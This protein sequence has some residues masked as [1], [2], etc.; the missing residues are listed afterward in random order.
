VRSEEYQL[1]LSACRQLAESHPWLQRVQGESAEESANSIKEEMKRFLGE[2]FRDRERVQKTALHTMQPLLAV[3]DLGLLQI[4]DLSHFAWQHH[5][6]R[7]KLIW[8]DVVLPQRPR[9]SH[10]F[11]LLTSN[12]AQALQAVRVLLLAGFEGQSRAMIR[13]FV[14]LADM[15]LA[16]VADEQ[17]Y[18][19]YI[20]VYEDEK[21]TQEHWRKHLAPGV[22]RQRLAKLDDELALSKIT[23]IPAAQVRQDTY[24]WVS[25]FSHVDLVAHL[26]SA[27]PQSLSGAGMAPLAMLGEV[28]EA[29]RATFARVL[30]YLWL[31]FIHF[32]RVLWAQ[33]RWNRFRGN[34]SRRWYQYRSSVFHTLFRENYALLQGITSEDSS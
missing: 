16:V 30:L 26:I 3:F 15:S 29:T 11:Y 17:C 31:F 12:L 4:C 2:V 8:P 10:V 21:K 7:V 14:E 1:L 23:S 20:T 18:R 34:R 24:K 19:H 27:Y 6:S 28:G 25:R 5:D 9:P 13:T 33:H 32:D 22:V